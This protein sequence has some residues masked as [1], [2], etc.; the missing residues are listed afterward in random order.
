MLVFPQR[1]GGWRTRGDP[2]LDKVVTSSLGAYMYLILYAEKDGPTFLFFF[3]LCISLPPA[4]S[5]RTPRL[6]CLLCLF[7]FLFFVFDLSFPLRTLS[8]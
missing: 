6:W 2:N 8:F 5:F 3:S 4:P 7:V 1:D